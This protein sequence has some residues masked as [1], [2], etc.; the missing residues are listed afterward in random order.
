[1]FHATNYIHILRY[2]LYGFL[3]LVGVLFIREPIP[4][5]CRQGSTA[6]VP[7]ATQRN[8]RYTRLLHNFMPCWLLPI[9]IRLMFS[10][11]PLSQ[12]HTL[13]CRSLQ[14]ICHSTALCLLGGS[15][16]VWKPRPARSLR[17]FIFSVVGYVYTIIIYTSANYR[18]GHA[19]PRIVLMQ[20]ADSLVVTWGL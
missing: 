3:K 14:Q 17:P 6:V 13:T 7:V 5:R 18:A 2:L 4:S 15:A 1:M 16:A 9:V 11:I 12:D 10:P 20:R 19:T 8:S